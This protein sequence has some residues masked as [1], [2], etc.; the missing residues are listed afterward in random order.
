M[1]YAASYKRVISD[2]YNSTA[3]LHSY[4]IINNIATQ[5]VSKKAQSIL[6]EMRCVE[7]MLELEVFCKDLHC[8]GDLDE[9]SEF[10]KRIV[11]FYAQEFT[12][13]NISRAKK[14]LE[15]RMQG[16]KSKETFCLGIYSGI[17]GIIIVAL[18]I[19]DFLS[20]KNI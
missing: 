5:K 15:S 4:C 20:N 1:S 9:I 7:V 16:N 17:I 8:F 19:L 18:F 13:S 2:L 14:E 6:E 12:E 11:Q 10:R 3:W